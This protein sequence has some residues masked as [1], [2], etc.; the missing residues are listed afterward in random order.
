MYE[1]ASRSLFQRETAL[2]ENVEL[3]GTKVCI[4][5]K[6]SQGMQTNVT[7]D[8]L[9]TLRTR[10]LRGC[11]FAPNPTPLIPSPTAVGTGDK[12]EWPVGRGVPDW[13]PDGDRCGEGMGLPNWGRGSGR[14]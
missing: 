8:A 2:S 12:G 10:W 1:Q 13:E 3:Q 6:K 14:W 9:H 7:G 11:H 5:S 4:N